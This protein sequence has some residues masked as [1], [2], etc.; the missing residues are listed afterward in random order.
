MEGLGSG[1]GECMKI[2][3]NGET[4][5]APNARTVA[6]LVEHFRLAPQTVLIEHNGLAL[7]RNE[8]ATRSL[9]EGDQI[10]F[11]RVVAGG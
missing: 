5:D 4:L 9:A 10:E 8:W 3:V 7:F 6:D 1:S 11:V 2:S